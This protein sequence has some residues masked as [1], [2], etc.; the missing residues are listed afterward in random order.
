MF[1][2][3]QVTIEFVNDGDF[4]SAY[5]EECVGLGLETGA[6]VC[7]FVILS[8]GSRFRIFGERDVALALC[9]LPRMG[10]YTEGPSR[11]SVRTR[12]LI[13]QTMVP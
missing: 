4:R 8:A 2:D 3:M 10:K 6:C 5:A 13:G 9:R 1:A 7:A 11:P 12:G